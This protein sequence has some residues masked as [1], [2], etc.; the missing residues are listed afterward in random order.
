[1]TSFLLQYASLAI[2]PF[3]AFGANKE[4]EWYRLSVGTC[5]IDEIPIMLEK[6]KAALDR[7]Q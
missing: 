5:P 4:S 1:M 6:L 7:L 2:V 3:S